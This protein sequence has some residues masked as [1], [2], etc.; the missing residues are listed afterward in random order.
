MHMG[1]RKNAGCVVV[2]DPELIR[3]DSMSCTCIRAETQNRTAEGKDSQLLRIEAPKAGF[4]IGLSDG[5]VTKLSPFG[6]ILG[7]Y[8]PPAGL[9]N[10]L[11]HE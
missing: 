1:S 8:G 10:V 6:R 4:A 5:L 9:T 7:G 3:S 11:A 2:R